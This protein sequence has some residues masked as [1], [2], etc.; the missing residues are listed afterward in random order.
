M[1]LEASK[2][3]SYLD[4]PPEYDPAPDAKPVEFLSLHLRELPASLLSQFSTALS[5]RQRSVLPTIRNRRLKYTSS[6]PAEFRFAEARRAWPT[7]WEG[8]ERR[9]IEEGADEKAW[10]NTEFLDGSIRPHVGKLGKMLGD[11][12]EER[13]A[14]RVRAIR[15]EQAVADEFIPEED[16]ESEDESSEEESTSPAGETPPDP[17][18]EQELFSRRLRERFIYGLLDT[19]LYEKVDWDD[20]LDEDREAEERWFDED[21]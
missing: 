11:L 20:N 14:E 18:A 3:L 19:P 12:E 16:E 2:I 6:D 4:L 1:S 10:A 15:R 5:P 13:E 9:G 8:R 7:L 21:D 17:Q